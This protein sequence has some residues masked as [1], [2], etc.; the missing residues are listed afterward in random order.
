MSSRMSQR[1]RRRRKPWIQAF[2]RSTTH[3]MVPSPDPWGHATSGDDRLDPALPQQASVLVVV[4]APV[5]MEPVPHPGLVPVPQPP[6]AG[7]ARAEAALLREPL[8][9]DPCVQEEQDPSETRAVVQRQPAG[10]ALTP[11]PYREQRLDPSPPVIR[12]YPRGRPFPFPATRSTSTPGEGTRLQQGSLLAA[13]NGVSK[14]RSCCLFSCSSG[15]SERSGEGI[16]CRGR[17]W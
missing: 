15:R 14:P 13:L 7:H 5:G 16:R 6:P 11:P 12:H 10:E 8:P 1:I 2:V 9:L 3:R 17:W 4:V